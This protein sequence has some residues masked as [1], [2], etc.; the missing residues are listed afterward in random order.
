MNKILTSYS[1][2]FN[3]KYRRTGRLFEGTF[4]A[5]HVDTD[6]YLKY[7]FAYIHLNPVKLIDPHWKENGILDREGAEKY[8]LR[9]KYSSYLDYLGQNR[10]ENA[11]LDKE[12]FPEYFEEQ[13]S[14][15]LFVQD[16]L[17]Y[18]ST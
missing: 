9:Y 11:L 6:E 5:Q 1:S 14:F 17:T 8:L 4:K 13:G 7:L 2:Y 15:E 16:W 12:S 3:K 10:I 18:R